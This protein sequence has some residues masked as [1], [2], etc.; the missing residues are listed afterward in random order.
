MTVEERLSQARESVGQRIPLQDMGSPI[1]HQAVALWRKLAGDRKYPPREVMTVRNLRS[2]LRN[3]TLVRV[4]DGGRDFEY[5]V[6]GDA[7]VM[8]HGVSFQGKRWSDLEAR[9]PGK[10]AAVKPIYD[11]VVQTGEPVATRGWIERC[12][13]NNEFVYCEYVHLPLGSEEGVVD[14]ILAVAVYAAHG[15]PAGSGY[16]SEYRAP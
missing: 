16:W 2:L 1:L 9:A 5:R 14:H 12:M 7:N 10:W 13:R 6:V 15:T 3:I 11:S 4:I 8:A